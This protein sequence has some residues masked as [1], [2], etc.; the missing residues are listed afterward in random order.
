MTWGWLVTVAAWTFLAG[1]AM[2]AATAIPAV[3][4]RWPRLLP[5]GFAVA[6]V[7]PLLVLLAWALP[8]LA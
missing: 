1:V 4:R 5:I 3:Q 6:A 2:A 8:R 7:S